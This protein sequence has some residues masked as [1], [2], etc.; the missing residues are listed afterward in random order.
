MTLNY[1]TKELLGLLLFISSFLFILLAIS[2]LNLC[3]NVDEAFSLM[4]TN[5]TYSNTTYLTAVDVH[6]PLYYYILKFFT[7]SLSILN[8]NPIFSGQILSIF[9]PL[10]LLIISVTKIRKEFG[11]LTCGVFAISIVSMP[12]FLFYATLIRM[13]SFAML[14][15][16]LSFIYMYDLIKEFNIKSLV[17]LTIFSILASYTHYYGAISVFCIYLMLLAHYLFISR[18]HFIPTFISAI[19]C[20]FAYIPWLFTVFNQINTYKGI[21]WIGKINFNSIVNMWIFIFSSKTTSSIIIGM[22]L[23]CCIIILIYIFIIQK[24]SLKDIYAFS[25][26]KLPVLTFLIAVLISIFIMPLFSERY[27]F[28]VL[29]A[30][31]LGFS[32]LLSRN[33]DKKKIFVPILIILIATSCINTLYFVNISDCAINNYEKYDSLVFSNNDI[34]IFDDLQMK[35]TFERWFTPDCT[36]FSY[37]NDEMDYNSTIN[38]AISNNRTVWIFYTDKG[39]EK[40]FDENIIMQLS[41]HF[42]LVKVFDL[43]I[44]PFDNFPT[45]IYKIE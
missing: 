42:N 28:P 19:T 3:L 21:Y 37:F 25:G 9:P 17:L 34:I 8:I 7:D 18:E 23:F 32:I 11:W 14:F 13:Y 44:D 39:S 6:P 45:K 1:N 31:W 40:E 16:T 10:I 35:L 4:I 26:L 5:T 20:V 2:K 15:V 29:G 27:I 41:N 22:L 36:C 38:E 43:Q 12:R 33:F 30:F 24:K